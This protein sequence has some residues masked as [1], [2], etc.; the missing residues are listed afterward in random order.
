MRPVKRGD[1]PKD[2]SGVD[3]VFKKHGE[4]RRYLIIRMGDYCSY[5]EIGL[6]SAID[7]EHV[8]PQKHNSGLSLVW[9]N[10]L[11]ACTYCNRAKWD[12]DIKLADYFWPDRDNTARAFVYRVDRAPQVADGLSG[13]QKAIAQ[14]TLE[15]TG[16]DCEPGGIRPPSSADRRWLKRREVWGVALRQLKKLRAGEIDREA[17]MHVA[18]GR[19]FWSVWMQVF[20]DDKDMRQLLINA[21]LVTP[22]NCFD[23]ST[24]PIP[25]VGGN[26]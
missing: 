11:L 1:V 26:L 22:T 15:L 20:C 12:D 17:V 2:G 14:K 6:H 7:V 21:F 24:N 18:I 13:P 9:T 3:I 4:A 10:F 5:C 8:L 19:G 25:R 16:L 23:A